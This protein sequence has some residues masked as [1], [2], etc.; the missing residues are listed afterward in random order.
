VNYYQFHVGD[1]RRDT[2]H[3]TRL[4]HS[5]Y[6]DLI[7]WYYLDEK[8]IP[9]KTQSVTRRLRLATQDERVALENVL[10]DFFIETAEGFTQ[11]RIEA[12]IKKYQEMADKN[13][14]NGRKGGRPK[15]LDKGAKTQSVTSGNPVK[16][17][18]KGNQEPLTTN[19]KPYKQVKELSAD[20][21]EVAHVLAGSILSENE[22]ARTNPGGWAKD[23][24][25]AMRIDNLTK[26]GLLEVINW[27]YHGG[28][29]FWKANILSGKKLREKYGTM[30]V[31][32]NR[33]NDYPARQSTVD[34]FNEWSNY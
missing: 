7:D 18:T 33:S 5:I 20:S 8:P 28:G 2:T 19:H 14:R 13:A 16:T 12:D 29:G 10:A 15:S 26:D 31:Q 24:D 27:I 4:E 9:L 17:Q 32:M 25:L 11:P 34:D 22:N 3:L 21:I 30:F 6:R 23:I 1:Y